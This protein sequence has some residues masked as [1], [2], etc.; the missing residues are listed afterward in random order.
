MGGIAASV[1]GIGGFAA[2][3]AGKK[4]ETTKTKSSPKK[5]ST[6]DVSIPYDAA[7]HLAHDEYCASGK[8]IDFE[9]FKTKYEQMT[10][11]SIKAKAMERDLVPQT[12]KVDVS[13]PYDAAAKL[14]YDQWLAANGKWGSD[15][16]YEK[17]KAK[18]EEMCVAQV[19]YKKLQREMA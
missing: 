11:A 15:A 16:E 17:Y 9:S 12:D 18:Y 1:L 3:K 10:V 13:I 14:A 6:A 7:A 8:E 5:K 2:T 19:T 4:T